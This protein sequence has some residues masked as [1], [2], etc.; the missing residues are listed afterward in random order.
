MEKEDYLE[1]V[2]AQKGH[3][4]KEQIVQSIDG[5]LSE[6]KTGVLVEKLLKLIMSEESNDLRK[7]EITSI[8]TKQFIK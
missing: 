6:L 8:L 1:K 7:K 5:M 3:E 2:L 4:T